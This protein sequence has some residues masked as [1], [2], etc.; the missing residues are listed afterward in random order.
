[1]LRSRPTSSLVIAVL[2]CGAMLHAQAGP[3]ADRAAFRRT[4]QQRFPTVETDSF[5]L[6]VYAI[7]AKL[8]A[9][10]EAINEFPPYEFALD[11]GADLVQT[12]FANGNYLRRCLAEN[13]DRGV[14][15][16]PYFDAESDA[17][18]TLPVAINRCRES[19]GED[20]L[21]YRRQPLTKILAHLN[22]AARGSRRAVELPTDERARAAYEAGKAYFYTK[23][24][25]LNLSCADCHVKAAGR[26]LR[27]QTLAPLLGVVNHYP[28]YG[29]RW[30][31]LGTL[32]QRFVGCLEQV[33]AEPDYPQSRV[34]RELE[35]FLAFMSNGLP[36]TGP[37]IHR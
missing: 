35:Y 30:G 37:G 1:M 16:Y 23:R 3:E 18:V 27:E 31:A 22:F 10:Y 5:V 20:R 34:F 28:V 14:N 12:A 19:N 15:Q 36:M 24:G 32:Q 21:S 8:R 26:H 7:D 33:R 9:Q 6:G 4:Y 25:Q 29:L 17:V 13:G 11:E 2:L